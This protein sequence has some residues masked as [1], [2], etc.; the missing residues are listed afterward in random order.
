MVALSS[1]PVLL[2]LLLAIGLSN[3]LADEATK[4]IAIIGGGISGSFVAQY[5]SEYDAACSFRSVT[6]FEPHPVKETIKSSDVPADHDRQHSRVASLELDDGSIV[7]LGASVMHESFVLISDMIQKANLSTCDPQDTG[8][9]STTLR[10]GLGV[11]EGNRS[12][13][14]LNTNHTRWNT[15]RT[16]YRYHLDLLMVRK[17]CQNAIEKFKTLA[18]RL[19]SLKADTFF[20]SPFEAW[21]ALGLEKAVYTSFDSLLTKVGIPED[22][23]WWLPGS[24]SMRKELLEA[25][26]LNNYNQDNAQVNGMI[27]LV[28]LASATGNLFSIQGGNYQLA[29]AA[30]RLA[31][32]TRQHHCKAKERDGSSS[33]QVVERRIHTVTGSL[34]GSTLFSDDGEELGRYDVVILAAAL[35]HAQI[36]FLVPSQNDPAILQDMPL[37]K[38]IDAHDGDV[39]DD[40]EG[41]ALLPERV[42]KHPYTQVVTT[43]IRKGVLNADYFGMQDENLLPQSILMNGKGKASN[44][45]ITTITQLGDGLYKVFSD[46][47]LPASVLN[48]LFGASHE[49]AFVQ[50]WGGPHGG[51]TPSYNGS[52]ENTPF[53]LYDGADGLLGHTSSGAIYYPLAMEQSSL[54]CIEVAAT[55]A[56][57][58]AKL[59]AER[60]ELIEKDRSEDAHDEL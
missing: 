43:V 2:Y 8:K 40:H 22:P 7:E 53:L 1:G 41:H 11:Y 10:T 49:R 51:A 45:N 3:V 38:L 36:S 19:R 14:L 50:L 6:I 28:M 47:E 32:E 27:G 21:K 16:L 23:R 52:G 4:T 44:H 46:E 12:W 37:G 13:P 39:P 18:E 17:L 24:G 5:L 34:E 25:A 57:A 15:A 33:I 35:Q 55:G 20:H 30:I 31:N 54:A 56:K 42:A 58:V 26:N 48:E 9:P 60:L 59:I 29:Q